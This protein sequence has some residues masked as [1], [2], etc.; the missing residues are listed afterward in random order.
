MPMNT[1]ERRWEK[2]T[3]LSFLLVLTP[4]RESKRLGDELVLR[5]EI[6][7]L[8]DEAVI[9]DRDDFATVLSHICL[10]GSKVTLAIR[11][12]NERLPTKLTPNDS[13]KFQGGKIEAFERSKGSFR[14]TW[15]GTQ[16]I[17]RSV[18]HQWR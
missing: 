7:F 5:I 13:D 11:R 12:L 8:D 9:L 3:C 2:F 6:L 17:R 1:P 18:F 10:K 16:H 14:L 4:Q 15:L